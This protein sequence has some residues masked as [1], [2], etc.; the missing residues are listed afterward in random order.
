MSFR[1]LLRTMFV[2]LCLSAL[3]V[4]V[5]GAEETIKIGLLAPL[6]GKAADDGLNVKNSVEMAVEKLNAAGGVLGK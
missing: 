4:S 1:K 6:T 2:V 5:A 3:L